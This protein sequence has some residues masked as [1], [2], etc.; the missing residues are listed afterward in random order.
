MLRGVGYATVEHAG[1]A[2]HSLLPNASAQSISA[3]QKSGGAPLLSIQ[4]HTEVVAKVRQDLQ[5]AFEAQIEDLEDKHQAEIHSMQAAF[6]TRA[7]VLSNDLEASS[8]PLKLNCLL[9]LKVIAA[10]KCFGHFW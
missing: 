3:N 8:T 10:P 7:E 1:A 5:E 9:A 2:A 6:D 4:E